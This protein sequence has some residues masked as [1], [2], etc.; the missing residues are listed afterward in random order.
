[1][2][3]WEIQRDLQLCIKHMCI[4]M[5]NNGEEEL[6]N[7]TSAQ[8]V[9]EVFDRIVMNAPDAMFDSRAYYWPNF[10]SPSLITHSF[11]KF[12]YSFGLSTISVLGEPLT[13]DMGRPWPVSGGDP[14][15]S[16]Q[17]CVSL[18][19]GLITCKG[20]RTGFHSWYYDGI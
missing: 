7:A 20:T 15:L 4:K 18:L 2:F 16:T 9:D 17:Q 14:F 5:A 19:Q 3:W 6:G 12:T 11:H 13:I 8:T 1:M 10:K